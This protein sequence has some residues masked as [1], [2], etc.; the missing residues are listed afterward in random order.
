MANNGMALDV[1]VAAQSYVHI[2]PRHLQNGVMFERN[3]L[4]LSMRPLICGGYRNGSVL[5][6]F[7]NLRWGNFFVFFSMANDKPPKKSF[8]VTKLKFS[9]FF[10]RTERFDCF[11]THCE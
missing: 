3:G 10:F 2:V 9:S 5:N 4:L 11:K 6:L 7:Q 1:A 8:L